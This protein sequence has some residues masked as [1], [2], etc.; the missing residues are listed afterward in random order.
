MNN[1]VT[2][3]CPLCGEVMTVI[4][5]LEGGILRC[6]KGHYRIKRDTFAGLWYGYERGRLNANAL[7]SD[8]VNLNTI[9]KLN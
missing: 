4:V 2:G 8:L 1:I 3:C 6:P 5:A 9:P 7:Y